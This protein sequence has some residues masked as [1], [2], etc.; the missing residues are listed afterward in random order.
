MR[1][2]NVCRH[3]GVSGA[4][5]TNGGSIQYSIHSIM[6]W[7]FTLLKTLLEVDFFFLGYAARW[8]CV[9]QLQNVDLTHLLIPP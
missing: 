9:N 8:I 2:F 4:V 6:V 1:C 3:F 5:Y 7:N